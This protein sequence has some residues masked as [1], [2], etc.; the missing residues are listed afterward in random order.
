MT[1]SHGADLAQQ[2]TMIPW[3]VGL[4]GGAVFDHDSP[5]DFDLDS[6]TLR[7]NNGYTF[8]GVAGVNITPVCVA[9]L[10]SPISGTA[11]S[12]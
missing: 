7:F 11:E 6:G 3:Y 2:P 1:P 12:T 4:F 9:S 10:N 5:A 8:G